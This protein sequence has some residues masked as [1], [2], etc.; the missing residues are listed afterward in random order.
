MKINRLIVLVFFVFI[1]VFSLALREVMD[2]RC[3]QSHEMIGVI[4][5]SSVLYMAVVLMVVLAGRIVGRG[6]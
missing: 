3:W 5:V 4:A 2:V 6:V 1:V